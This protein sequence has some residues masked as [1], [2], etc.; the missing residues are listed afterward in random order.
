MA[1]CP[2]WFYGGK[3]FLSIREYPLPALVLAVRVLVVTVVVIIA[4]ILY[5]IFLEWV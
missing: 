1:W 4:L 5:H 3:Y 2:A